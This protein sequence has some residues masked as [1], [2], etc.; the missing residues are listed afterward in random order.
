LWSL[1]RG[2]LLEQQVVEVSVPVVTA[3]GIANQGFGNGLKSLMISVV[4]LCFK[5][6][7]T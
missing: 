3:V 6:D 7:S 1:L 4:L 5:S 2:V